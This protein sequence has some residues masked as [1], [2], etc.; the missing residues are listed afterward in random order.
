[1]SRNQKYQPIAEAHSVHVLP[2]EHAIRVLTEIRA[3]VLEHNGHVRSVNDCKNNLSEKRKKAEEIRTALSP[4]ASKKVAGVG[5][6]AGL[7]LAIITGIA[8]R[9]FLIG[10][11][12]GGIVGFIAAGIVVAIIGPNDRKLHEAENNQKAEQ[13]I[14]EHVNPAQVKLN[15]VVRKHEAFQSS[16][17]FDWAVD[18]VG[19][20]NCDITRLD[21]LL[22]ILRMGRAS[23]IKEAVNVYEEDL[24]RQ[25]L[26]QM[27]QQRLNSQHRA[28]TAAV[29][30]ATATVVNAK[31]EEEH[32]REE[33][34]RWQEEDRRR[35]QARR[36]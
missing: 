7:A 34:R 8:M 16:G 17:K 22:D 13:Y 36:R 31:R 32:R 27:E 30:G 26:E 20:G 28:E 18:A 4:E 3:I 10:L 14:S 19:T 23:N 29:I 6:A 24:H 21:A 9:S 5:L 25:K 1:M 15:E 35:A 12:C 33:K 11:I 2:R